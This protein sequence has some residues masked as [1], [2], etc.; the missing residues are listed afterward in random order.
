MAQRPAP[1]GTADSRAPEGARFSTALLRI[2]SRRG[3][4]AYALWPLSMLYG[5][6][7]ALRQWA[8]QLGIRQSKRLGVPVLVVGNV[9]AGGAGKTPVVMML[10]A[11]FAAQGVRVGVVSRGYGRHNRDCREVLDGSPALDVGDEPKLLKLATGVPVFVAPSRYDAGAALLEKYPSTQLIVCDDGLQHHALQRDLEICVFDDR[12]LGNGYL[13]P[14]GPLREAWPRAVDFVLHTGQSPAAIGG[15]YTP[16]Q[17]SPLAQNIRGENIALTELAKRPLAAVAAIAQPEHF[18]SMLRTRGLTLAHTLALP[19]HFDFNGWQ[20][21]FDDEVTIVCT[22]KDAVKLWPLH[23]DV[24]AV[25]LT[26]TP[27][28]AFFAQLDLAV[29]RLLKS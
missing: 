18:F 8:Y 2:W 19:D 11:H 24:L 6:V 23:P 3:V 12:G 9:V 1:H 27:D 26:L 28:P 21:P 20:P 17:L 7:I 15:F 25:P 4:A 5:L 22:Q 14:A 29:K 10:A 16:R 13:L